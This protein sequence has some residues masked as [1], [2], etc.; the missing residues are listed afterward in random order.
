MERLIDIYKYSDPE[1]TLALVNDRP[2]RDLN[3]R[4]LH[5]DAP[6]DVLSFP[7]RD[8][9][10][11]GRYYLGDILI[12]VPYAAR[13]SKASGHGLQRELEL[14]AIHGFLHLQ[15]FDHFK[16]LEQEEKRI[17]DLWSKES[18]ES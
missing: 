9:A 18:D 11:D 8:H 17:Q 2:M 15:G 12:G 10:P 3:R 7:I 6:T 1:V 14:L 4:F 16:G 13:Q 5:K